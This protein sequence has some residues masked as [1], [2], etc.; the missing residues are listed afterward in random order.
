MVNHQDNDLVFVISM[1]PQGATASHYKA[2]EGPF[3]GLHPV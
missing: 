1:T 2:G 3:E